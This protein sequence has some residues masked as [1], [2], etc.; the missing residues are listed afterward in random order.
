MQKI[1]C[2]ITLTTYYSKDDDVHHIIDVIQYPELGHYVSIHLKHDG[3]CFECGQLWEDMN[4][5]L[6]CPS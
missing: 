4:H 5:V 2:A 1:L 6:H 3:Q